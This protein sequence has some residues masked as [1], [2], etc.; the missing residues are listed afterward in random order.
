MKKYSMETV[1]GIFV[2]V[3]LL[4]IAYMSV[5]LGKVSFF[6]TD[7]YTL[8]ARFSSVE[9]LRIGSPVEI[10]G[11]EAGSISY[12]GI[13][14]MRQVALVTM[15]INKGVNTYSD[16]AASVKTMGLIGDK[17]IKID[18]GGAGTPLKSGDSITNTAAAPDIEDLLGKYIFGQVKGQPEETGGR[19]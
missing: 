10:F 3:G 4:C 15:R 6:R 19:K 12:L 16:A 11:I 13:D 1:I 7:T 5:K 2:V 9:G 18:P 8:Y 14:N 17:Y